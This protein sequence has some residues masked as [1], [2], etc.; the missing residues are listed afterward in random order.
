[1]KSYIHYVHNIKDDETSWFLSSANH[2]NRVE[3]FRNKFNTINELQQA[4]LKESNSS[5]FRFVSE[6]LDLYKYFRHIIFSTNSKSYVD[7][8][9]FSNVRA[10]INFKPINNIQEINE[11]L[12]SVNKLLPDAGIYIGSIESYGERKNRFCARYGEK[13]GRIIWLTDFVFNRIIPKIRPLQKLYYF[14]TSGKNHV[15]SRAE[16]LGRLVYNGFEIIEYKYIEGIL[17]FV[18]IKTSEPQI[19]LNPSYNLIIKLKRIGRNGNMINV[20]KFRTMHPYSEFLHDYILKLNGYNQVGKPAD[21]FRVARWGKLLRKLWLDELP[22]VINLLK[23]EMKIVGVRPLS[24][25]RF[26]QLPSDLQIQRIKHKPGCF[27]PYVA[28]NMPDDR[29]NILAERIYLDERTHHPLTTD[30]KYFF[31]ALYNIITNKIRSA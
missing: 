28:L 24:M 18:V 6:H 20:Y 10:I 5:V 14:F 26:N 21:D 30:I 31:L 19:H 7:N 3:K 2:K 29:A 1:M 22:Q 4:I 9:D 17:Y 13:L 16:I 8:V 11:H 15:V 27:P 25:V 23:G 12:I